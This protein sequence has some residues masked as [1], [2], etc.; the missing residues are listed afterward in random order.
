MTQF[1]KRVRDFFS[2]YYYYYFLL[3]SGI[4]FVSRKVDGVTVRTD[5]NLGGHFQEMET[6]RARIRW[7]SEINT[8]GMAITSF[9]LPF[10]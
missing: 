6:R 2:Y 5:E 8:V 7:F 10:Y 3:L 9:F 1:P 4:E